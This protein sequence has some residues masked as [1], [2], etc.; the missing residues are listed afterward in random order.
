MEAILKDPQPK[1]ALPKKMGLGEEANRGQY[2]TPCGVNMGGWQG[3]YL[4]HQHRTSQA[5]LGQDEPETKEPGLRGVRGKR[6][7]PVW[8]RFPRISSKRL[9]VEKTLAKVTK[10]FPQTAK[11]KV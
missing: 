8:A 10:Q 2:P 3:A 1:A 4:I 5:S 7:R 9:E 6:Y 11:R